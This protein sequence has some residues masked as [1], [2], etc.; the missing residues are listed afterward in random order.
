MWCLRFYAI[1]A[2]DNRRVERTLVVGP[3]SQLQKEED[4]RREMDRKQLLLYINQP[5]Q[6]QGPI[7]FG[8]LARRWEAHEL[9]PENSRRA[10]STRKS[11]QMYLK[12]HILP[13][14]EKQVVEDMKPLPIEDWL[15]ELQA[16]R[17]L[18]NGTVVRLRQ[19]MKLVIDWGVK[20]EMVP[21]D[22]D[23]LKHVQWSS[24][25]EYEP[26]VIAPSQAGAI[27]RHLKAPASTM[28]LLLAGTGMRVSEGL[29]L[30][31]SD[32]DRKEGV[33]SIKRSWTAAKLGK[34]KTKAS[35]STLPL[36]PVLA[37]HLQ[38]WRDE[39]LFNGAE[40]FVFPSEVRGG[41]IP[42]N[43]GMLLKD[44]VIPAAVRAG[45]IKTGERVGW[46]ALRHGCAS[47]LVSSGLNP[48]TAQRMLRHANVS[49]TLQ[50][51]THASSSDLAQAQDAV[52]REILTSKN[53]GGEYGCGEAA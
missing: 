48:S 39:T 18:A 38:K 3:C 21:K 24:V 30:R 50:T 23:P 1:R 53:T 9:V 4:A 7:T 6:Y 13:R 44:Y 41:K 22:T 31:W 45:V 8:D 15:R 12:L 34:T 17:G 2:L 5:D 29:G 25:S 35:R 40:D 26:K 20:Y 11:Y 49:Q 47:Y 42:R 32:I 37:E 52:M 51:Y 36:I 33:L 46:H 28:L 16:K 10:N 19:I 14:W 43:G 27:L